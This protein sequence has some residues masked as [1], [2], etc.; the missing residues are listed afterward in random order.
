MLE[1]KKAKSGNM[2]D[3]EVQ[4]NESNEKIVQLEKDIEKLKKEL[5]SIKDYINNY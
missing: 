3:Y 1:R 5:E 2:D 4:L